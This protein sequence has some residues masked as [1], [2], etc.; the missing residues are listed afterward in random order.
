[1]TVSFSSREM[2]QLLASHRNSDFLHFP[3]IHPATYSL[4][5]NKRCVYFC[6]DDGPMDNKEGSRGSKR[7]LATGQS[8]GGK[9]SSSHFKLKHALSIRQVLQS[10]IE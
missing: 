1:M 3:R 9:P 2:A 4:V 6:L 7:C 10:R 8:F 5:W